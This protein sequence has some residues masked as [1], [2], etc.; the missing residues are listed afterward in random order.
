MLVATSHPHHSQPFEYRGSSSTRIRSALLLGSSLL[1]SV[2][3]L[4]AA[5]EPVQAESEGAGVAEPA[6]EAVATESPTDG[7][8]A[9]VV[10]T[11]RN[12]SERLQDVPLSIS[13]VTGEQ[14][15]Q[16]GA[17]DF[18]AFSKRA[19]NVTV[20]RDNP[21]HRAASI[22]G[23]GKM[24]NTHAQDPSVGII[25]DGVNYAYNPLAASVE[26]TDISSVE[27]TRGPQG[28]LQGKNATLGVI[29]IITKR[30]SFTPDANYSLTFGEN[31]TFIGRVSGGGP[32]V[33]DL[34]AWRG[35]FSVQKGAGP[36]DNKYSVNDTYTNADRVSG[37][38][39]VLLTPSESFSARISV[40]VQPRAG[41]NSN[42]TEFFTPTPTVYA[43]GTANPLSSDASTRLARRWFLQDGNY[44]YLRDYLSDDYH[45]NDA[46][47][48]VVVGSNGASVELNWDLGKYNVTSISAYN[49][50]HFNARYNDEGT[51]FAIQLGSGNL[52][53]YKQITQELRL[54]SEIGE[55][56]DYQ[57]GLYFINTRMNDKGSLTIYGSDAGAWYANAS[58][59]ALLDANSNGRYLMQNSLEDLSVIGN[60]KQEIDNK[61]AAI[62]GQA[63][64]HLSPA[65]TLTTG[66]RLT[67]EERESKNIT[68]YI[69]SHGY[70]PELNPVSVN[71][72]Q[73]GGFDSHASTGA[74][75]STDPSQIALANSAALKY[76]GAA[77]YAELT[78]AQ[79]RQ[80]AAAKTI[81]RARM[82]V[83]WD[84][85]TPDAWTDTQPAVV[86]SQSYRVS[87]NVNSYVS[88]Q[89][90]EK[91]GI[92]QVVYGKSNP[93]KA[94][95]NSSYEFGVKTSL[96]RGALALN[97][98]I[99][100]TSIKDYQQRVFIFDEYTTALNAD[101]TNYYVGVT[102]NAPEV[103]A[104]GFEIDGSY[105]GLQNTSIRF[106]GAYNDAIY[107]DFKNAGQPLENGNQKLPYRDV[108][109]QNLPGAAK[110]TFNVG[111]DYRVP[112]FNDK[113]LRFG[114]NTAY[115]SKFKSD[116]T[117]SEY[118]WIPGHSITDLSIGLGTSGVL[119]HNFEVSLLIKNVFDEDVPFLRTWNSFTPADPRWGAIV[120][121][122]KL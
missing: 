66:L 62:F 72:V 120:L 22:R 67:R 27:V 93:A 33:D 85:T 122:G 9:T 82:G 75:L 5:E 42:G 73:L 74:L 40:D 88:W 84:S 35:A 39:Q 19:A 107:E 56:V 7:T 117:L 31:D 21:Q 119:G 30:P 17:S 29:N 110:Y 12:R 46:R 48:P 115:T 108:T 63:N 16:L 112:V 69:Q 25:V 100:Q 114:F 41:E 14:L 101:G 83:L 118:S 4:R 26:Y 53:Y 99:F 28:T 2:P 34:I 90:G 24:S 59:Y 45:Y 43:D 97:A 111:V 15:E 51:P 37:R 36:W 113:E 94:E 104:R 49:D 54:S 121:T 96:F 6:P 44:S 79:R 8:L 91:A 80:V 47:H 60:P 109:G 1:L 3:Q 32:I 102:G 76:F 86:V 70:A 65:L 11:A 116:E 87:D 20:S 50:F 18:T 98:D 52:H 68:S 105:D 61:S 64:W 23:I 57:T 38:G 106:A 77:T 92:S 71:G 103:R 10:V 95:K 55:L 58:Q 13:V 81:R 78:E 89:Y